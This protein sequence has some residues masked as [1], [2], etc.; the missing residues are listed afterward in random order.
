MRLNPPGTNVY[1]E[2]GEGLLADVLRKLL[3]SVE[4]K[5]GNKQNNRHADYDVTN[6]GAETYSRSRP[7]CKTRLVAVV[8]GENRLLSHD[9]NIIVVITLSMA[10]FSLPIS[11]R[12]CYIR[13]TFL[14]HTLLY[15][16]IHA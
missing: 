12:S 11:F 2:G 1:W 16:R 6:A 9:N 13:N 7:V 15:A 5:M 8:R 4:M 14:L 3:S 10:F